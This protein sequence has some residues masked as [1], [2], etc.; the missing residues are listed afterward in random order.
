MTIPIVEFFIDPIPTNFYLYQP[1]S[2]SAPY[3]N[4]GGLEDAKPLEQPKSL[5]FF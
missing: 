4:L 3:A 5:Q 1:I 2:N